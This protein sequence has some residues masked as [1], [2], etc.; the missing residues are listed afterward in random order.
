MKYIS[1]AAEAAFEPGIGDSLLSGEWF[2]YWAQLVMT[3]F[4]Y[5][6]GGHQ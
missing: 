4:S 2:N 1:V 6:V 5:V 3:S